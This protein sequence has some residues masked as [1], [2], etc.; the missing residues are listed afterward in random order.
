MDQGGQVRRK[1]DAAIVSDLQRQPGTASAIRSG[2]QPRE[3]PTSVGAAEVGEALVVDHTTREAH[4]D[5]SQ[6][7]EALGVRDLPDGRGGGSTR[8]VC[9]DPGPHPA[10]RCAASVGATWLSV[11]IR[12][13]T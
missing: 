3:L 1:V 10:L 11:A 2:V 4:Q 8:V 5:R 7:G 13:E 9:S 12:Q 6:G